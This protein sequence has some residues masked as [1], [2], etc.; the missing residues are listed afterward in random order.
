MKR[1]L[2]FAVCLF[3]VLTVFAQTADEI[4]NLLSMDAVSYA[5][6]ARL[7]LQAAEDRDMNAEAA[8][9]FAW[10]KGWLPKGVKPGDMAKLN[11]LSLLVMKAFDIKGGLFYTY[12]GGTNYAYRELVYL[13]IIQGRSDPAMPV[14]GDLLLYTVNRVLSLQEANQL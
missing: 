9:S 8:F 14:S 5:Q 1:F 6:A 10:E 7:V 11:G 12:I 2:L 3:A 4:E 13:S